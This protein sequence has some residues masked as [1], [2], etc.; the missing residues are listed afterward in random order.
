[1]GIRYRTKHSD[2]QA[3]C[4]CWR[5]VAAERQPPDYYWDQS[6]GHLLAG[7]TK[8]INNLKLT[9]NWLNDEIL[10]HFHPFVFDDQCRHVLVTW[11]KQISDPP[12][13]FWDATKVL[14]VPL[15]FSKSEFSAAPPSKTESQKRWDKK[16]TDFRCHCL[17]REDQAHRS[18][19]LSVAVSCISWR[20]L[21]WFLCRSYHFILSYFSLRLLEAEVEL[22]PGWGHFLEATVLNPTTQ[23]GSVCRNFFFPA[24][25]SRN[26][27]CRA[28]LRA[29]E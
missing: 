1:M 28:N 21:S 11:H 18:H 19:W 10:S 20:A 15:P 4:Y 23:V 22:T 17:H 27:S 7:C 6:M 3:S 29:A 14:K 25:N 2:F 26:G 24:P 8:I 13:W 12:C 5:F 9:D 16:T